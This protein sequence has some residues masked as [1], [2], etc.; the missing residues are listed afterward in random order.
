MAENKSIILLKNGTVVSDSEG[1]VVDL[2]AF[3]RLQVEVRVKVPS[4]AGE[5]LQL[6]H[7]AANE[8]ELFVDLGPTY[9]L[10]AAGAVVNNYSS[11][12]RY[13]RFVASSSISTQPTLTVAMIAKEF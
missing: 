13:V 1:Q 6:Q 2:L 3:C 10:D 12:L 5:T 4:N 7:A 9:A 11:F 8:S